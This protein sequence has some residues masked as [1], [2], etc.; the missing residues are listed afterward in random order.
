[1]SCYY[2]IVFL[3][4]LDQSE[5]VLVMIEC[6][7]LLVENGN[8]IIYCLED[9]GCCQLVYLI[10]NLVKVYYVMFNIEVDQVVLSELV[11]SFCFNDVVLCNFVIKCDEVDIEQLLIMKSK[12][13]KGDKFEC[14]E[15]CC[16]DDEEG[17]IIFVVDNEVGEDVVLVV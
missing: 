2:E 9:W 14:G 1:M 3:V 8:G 4:Y 11:E 10:Q 16:C 7:K 12:D 13:E 5:Q 17:E 6:Y 15:C